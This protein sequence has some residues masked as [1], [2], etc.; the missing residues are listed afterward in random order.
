MIYSIYTFLALIAANLPC[1]EDLVT[2]GTCNWSCNAESI[3]I[4]AKELERKIS[5]G[6]MVKLKIT[7]EVSANH[8]LDANDKTEVAEIWVKKMS[9]SSVGA[10]QFIS[11]FLLEDVGLTLFKSSKDATV[12]CILK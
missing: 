5:Q 6:E 2:E 12:T 7:Y 11:K 3:D 9:P 10:I 1:V 8:T 4:D